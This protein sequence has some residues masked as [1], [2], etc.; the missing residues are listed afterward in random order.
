MFFNFRNLCCDLQIVGD[1]ENLPPL[2]VEAP[3]KFTSKK[4]HL[5]TKLKKT[6]PQKERQQGQK[7]DVVFLAIVFCE[8]YMVCNVDGLKL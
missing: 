6:P 3:K 5:A 8:Q 4:M 7:N 2:A 1:L